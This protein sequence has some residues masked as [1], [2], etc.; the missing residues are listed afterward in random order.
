MVGLDRTA[1]DRVAGA[2]PRVALLRPDEVAAP[3]DGSH[4]LWGRE[5]RQVE[6]PAANRRHHPAQAV[7]R[8]VPL[9]VSRGDRAAVLVPVRLPRLVRRT[10]PPTHAAQTT[11]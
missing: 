1:V 11:L 9:V 3:L 4:R 5:P 6:R 2:V 7:L 8:D 10:G